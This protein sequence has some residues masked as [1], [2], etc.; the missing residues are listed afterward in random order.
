MTSHAQNVPA[1]ALPAD[2]TLLNIDSEAQASQVP[3]IATISAG[4]VTEGA[5]GNT[6][7][8]DNAAQMQRVMTAIREAGIAEK[9][10]RTSGINL[11]PRYQRSS[12]QA[13]KITG[14]EARNTVSLK[15]RDISRLGQVLDALAKQGANQINGP[16]FEI[17]NP[18]PVFDK[19]RQAALAQ[20]QARAQTYAVS[21]GMKVRRIVSI[22]EGRSGGVRPVPMM[23]AMSAESGAPPV[24]PGETTVSVSLQVAF[25]LGK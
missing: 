10:I 3:D 1:Y 12:N 4:V 16:S 23:R 13:P 8:R 5:D 24:A 25:E 6:A 14:Y 21:L 18:E 19:A 22:S 20:A 9:D 2:A 11:S 15:V 7:M 17:D